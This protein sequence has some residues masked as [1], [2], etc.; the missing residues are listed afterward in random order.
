MRSK[1]SVGDMNRG[2]QLD[3]TDRIISAISE[4]RRSAS[5]DTLTSI[6]NRMAVTSAHAKEAGKAL[7]GTDVEFD[8]PGSGLHQQVDHLLKERDRLM[9][10]LVGERRPGASNRVSLRLGRAAT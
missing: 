7:I 4:K 9:R 8:V 1:V 3:G 5:F 2:D 10:R 6:C